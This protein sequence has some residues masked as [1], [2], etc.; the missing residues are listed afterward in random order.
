MPRR[1][2]ER[3]DPKGTADFL[4]GASEKFPKPVATRYAQSEHKNNLS[5]TVLNPVD[6]AA[7][8]TDTLADLRAGMLEDMAPKALKLLQDAINDPENQLTPEYKHALALKLLD[9][10]G[11]GKQDQAPRANARADLVTLRA[12]SDRLARILARTETRSD[13]PD[14]EAMFG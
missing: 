7:L 4:A 2:K 13:T 14:V 3:R 6:A 10:V 12:V 5:Q 8:P 11:A 9:R 1:T